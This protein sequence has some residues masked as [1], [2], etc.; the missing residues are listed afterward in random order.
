MDTNFTTDDRLMIHQLQAQYLVSNE[1]PS[2]DR[3]K[4]ALDEAVARGLP[5][6][7]TSALA[8]WFRKTDSSVWLIRSLEVDVDL[9]ADW[10][11]EQLARCLGGPDRPVPGH[12]R[13]RPRRR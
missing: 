12:H 6:A 10:G 11:R 5:Q 1:H 3:L 2:P 8:P 7:L 9:N 4:L 13:R